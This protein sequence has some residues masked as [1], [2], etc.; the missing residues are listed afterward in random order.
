[1]GMWIG[2][3]HHRAFILGQHVEYECLICII[4]RTYLKDLNIANAVFQT[5][6]GIQPFPFDYDCTDLWCRQTSESEVMSGM[7][8]DDIAATANCF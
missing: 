3:S 8:D 7:E 2:A 5:P 4:T 6:L 1:M